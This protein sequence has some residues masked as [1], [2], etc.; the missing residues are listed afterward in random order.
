MGELRHSSHRQRSS[1]FIPAVQPLASYS[2]APAAFLPELPALY[3]QALANGIGRLQLQLLLLLQHWL[4]CTACAAA[5]LHLFITQATAVATVHALRA[6]H[7]H[8][9]LRRSAVVNH[10]LRRCSACILCL[11]CYAGL[12]ALVMYF[13]LCR[14]N[15]QTCS[16][17]QGHRAMQPP[18][19]Q[20]LAARPVPCA[21]LSPDF[22]S[23][24]DCRSFRDFRSFLGADPASFA[25]LSPAGR[26]H[27]LHRSALGMHLL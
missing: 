21:F 13:P 25:T 6:A 24:R 2:A 8:A 14:A 22:R 23:F 1:V 26:K 11:A 15:D 27:C 17:P 19:S 20:R 10:A 18:A 12:F 3:V 7:P 4:R 5:P 16:P 9:P